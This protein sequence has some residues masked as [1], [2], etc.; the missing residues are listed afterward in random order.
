MIS[1]C[2]DMTGITRNRRVDLVLGTVRAVI[3]NRIQSYAKRLKTALQSEFNDRSGGVR[4]LANASVYPGATETSYALH[5][6]QTRSHDG[7]ADTA[8]WA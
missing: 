7:T 3:A 2:R 1:H 6:G 8:F 5:R 4:G